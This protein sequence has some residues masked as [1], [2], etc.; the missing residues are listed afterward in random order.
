MHEPGAPQ[1]REVLGHVGYLAADPFA[2][3]RHRQLAESERLEDAQPL[4]IGERTP[5][6]GIAQSLGLGRNRRRSNIPSS[7]SSLAQTRK[8]PGRWGSDAYT[9]GHV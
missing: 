8:Y 9:R 2:E 6:R 5:D 3:V 7:M 1:H 4:W